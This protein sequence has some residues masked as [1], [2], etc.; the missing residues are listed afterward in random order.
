M[1]KK[2]EQAKDIVAPSN[3]DADGLDLALNEARISAAEGGIPIGSCIITHVN[4]K[5]EVLAA[6]H[7]QRI[8]KNSAILHG[9]TAALECA[10]RQKA[11]VYRKSTI[12]G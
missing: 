7:N 4:G 9:E 12:V 10:G 2:K 5:R 3:D 1:Y 8:Q 6:S 11:D